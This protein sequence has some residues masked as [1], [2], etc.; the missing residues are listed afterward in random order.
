MAIATGNRKVRKTADKGS[1][2]RENIKGL[3][4]KINLNK[5]IS[6][7]EIGF[8]TNQ[9]S[10]MVEIGTPLNVSLSSIAGQIK[11]PEFRRVVT[12]INTDV[13][14]GK[15]LS[16]ALSRHPHL[17]SEIYVSMV[18]AGE[19][20]GQLKDMLDRVV[21]MQEKQE[22]F[23]MRLKKAL[24]Y[25]AVLCFVSAAVVI[26]LLVFVFP[27]FA[28]M[29]EEI[30][31]ILPPSTK[32]LIWLSGLL[33]SYWHVGVVLLG[34]S[35]WGVY[36][37]IK[38]EKGRLTVHRLKLNLPLVSNIFIL[39]YLAQTMR[40]LGFLMSGNV[41]LIDALRITRKS[42]TNLV[43]AGFI[44]K[45]ADNVQE[46]KG[47]AVAFTEAAFVPENAKQIIRTGEETQNLPKVMLR[48][49]DHY[50]EEIDDKLQ[51]LSTIIE[52]ALLIM[53]GVVVGVIVISLILPIFKLS[54]TMH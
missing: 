16:D 47:M 20:T 18:K 5:K 50:E 10:L 52:P 2:L 35:S 17:F 38:S 34:M 23:V 48:L 31:D 12:E 37:F 27:R 43:F 32:L 6:V 49:S 25:P 28:A 19:S 36:V 33:T 29:F 44:E 13:E 3:D 42:S 26:F 4:F 21:E 1:S 8:F 11:N 15:L 14:G 9:L 7:R 22:K 51:K 30:R 24:T 46:G 41:P 54:K 40:I 45:I 39:T 53:M